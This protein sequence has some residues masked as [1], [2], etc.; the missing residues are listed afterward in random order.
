M[1]KYMK[2][3]EQLSFVEL[4]KSLSIVYSFFGL[5]RFFVD[6]KLARLN[7]IKP[8]TTLANPYCVP[9]ICDFAKDQA[10]FEVSTKGASLEPVGIVVLIIEYYY[11]NEFDS[12]K[13]S[14]PGSL[15]IFTPALV[16]V[17]IINPKKK[18]KIRYFFSLLFAYKYSI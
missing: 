17:N 10:L 18:K 11:L 12:H 9:N 13:C 1:C 15:V 3:T 2:S 16:N 6:Q 7:I 14:K 8:M 5:Q 4:I